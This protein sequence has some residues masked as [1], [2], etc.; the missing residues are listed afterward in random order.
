MPIPV[1]ADAILFAVNTARRLGRG[2][3]RAYVNSLRSRQ[4]VLPLPTFDRT[5]TLLS[6]DRFFSD[7]G[8]EYL[9]QIEYLRFLHDK[10]QRNQLTNAEQEAYKEYYITLFS[11]KNYGSNTQELDQV[12]LRPEDIINLLR[13]RQWEKGQ[14][15]QPTALQ[16]A[17]GTLVE[18][19]IDFYLNRP[20]A[21]TPESAS[22]RALRT[23]LIAL[24]DI[25]LAQASDLD[26]AINRELLPALF[27][28]AAE[29]IS[30]L[31]PSLTDDPALRQ[32]IAA[33]GQQLAIDLREKTRQLTD[34]T[35]RS[36]KLQ[37]GPVILR[38]VVF[39]LAET[40]V[41]QAPDLFRTAPS[42]TTLIQETGRLVLDILFAE[43]EGLAWSDLFTLQSLDELVRTTLTVVQQHPELIGKK[44][45]VQ[46]MAKDLS[47]ALANSGIRQRALLPHIL[48]LTLA[49]TGKHIPLFWGEEGRQNQALLIKLLQTLITELSQQRPG[50]EWHL[51]WQ[52]N[53]L[54]RVADALLDTV[55]K[56]PE[57]LLIQVAE[58]PLV[59]WVLQEILRLLGQSPQ[60][61]RWSLDHLLLIIEE[62]ARTILR[63][64]PLFAESENWLRD[65]LRLIVDRLFADGLPAM[66]QLDQILGYAL[67]EL[68]P[69][70]P[71]QSWLV[72][73]DVLLSRFLYP[74]RWQ[75]WLDHPELLEV[76]EELL[77][78]FP[79]WVT[80]DNPILP[81]LRQAEDNLRPILVERPEWGAQILLTLLEVLTEERSLISPDPE[82]ERLQPL[83]ASTQQIGD[84]WPVGD[85][86]S[87]WLHRLSL[88]DFSDI[89]A[90]LIHR[91]LQD[92]ELLKDQQLAHLLSALSAAIDDYDTRRHLPTG[93]LID[94]LDWMLELALSDAAWTAPIRVR[95][96]E[97]V[98]A[99]HY[100][101][102]W[103]MAIL[104]RQNRTMRTFLSRTDIFPHVIHAF[105]KKCEILGLNERGIDRA[106]LELNEGLL[107]LS[108]GEISE[109]AFIQSIWDPQVG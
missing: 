87:N 83:L 13:I 57:L 20:D 52:G 38:S 27:V 46:A 108:E 29:A 1:T 17:A 104:F 64:P 92:Q 78:A 73:T 43:S 68:A 60:K 37:W 21:P 47:K 42:Q 24:D 36:E 84:A 40:G 81:F 94:L 85:R 14:Q 26:R 72:F 19:G 100:A 69:R 11:L 75:A 90:M 51:R 71:D 50:T 80:L 59:Q 106:A 58:K 35:A 18:T 53:D 23:L 74:D 54:L 34:A 32:Y 67:R 3:Q 79:A 97:Q 77:R 48:R 66:N 45:W 76:L 98:T 91:S 63:Y 107:G 70:Y 25:S 65:F 44:E 31:G 61:N 7:D 39:H 49:A 101:T 8:R 41:D 109:T 12:A 99:I 86:Q 10:Q 5:P 82:A 62:I 9:D 105:A 33:T 22:G 96:R 95:N 55:V 4:I 28:G 102:E 16:I 30:E 93:H 88:D 6:A 103:L 56:H 89:F 2:L 15:P